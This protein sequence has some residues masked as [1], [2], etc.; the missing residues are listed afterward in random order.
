[1]EYLGRAVTCVH[2]HRIFTATDHEVRYDGAHANSSLLERAERL[3]ALAPTK[4]T[5]FET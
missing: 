2:C 4:R 5:L 3:L 1:V